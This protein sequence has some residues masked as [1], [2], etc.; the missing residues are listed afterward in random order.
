MTADTGSTLPGGVT[1]RTS[2]VPELAVGLT[3]L[4]LLMSTSF[5]LPFT[6]DEPN[7][8]ERSDQ[9]GIWLR[10]WYHRDL[11]QPFPWETD[12]IRRYCP[13]TTVSEGHPDFYGFVI[14]IGRL[15]SSDWLPP[16]ESYRFGPMLLFAVATACFFYRMRQDHGLIAAEIGVACLLSMPRLFAHA[17]FASI[18][19]PLT[20]CWI[21]MWATFDWAQRSKTGCF[22]WG[23]MLGLT[24]S[25]K[26]TG[27]LA[28]VPFVVWSV[29]YRHSW[30][31]CLL[32]GAIAVVTFVNVNPRLWDDPIGGMLQFLSLNLHRADRGLNV[33]SFFFGTRY[34]MHHPL[35]WY[36]PFVW[37]LVTV[38][39]GT[40]LM[41]AFGSI[42]SM[43]FW[44]REPQAILL[45][46]NAVILVIVKSM[47]FAPGHDAE[48]LFLPCFA[49]VAAL[50]GI[51]GVRIWTFVEGT[52]RRL[53]SS[54]PILALILISA[55][56]ETI[57]YAPQWLSYYSPLIGGLRGAAQYGM[58]PTYY[59][60]GLDH[61]TVAWLESH[62]GSNASVYLS[63]SPE[64]T[65]AMNRFYGSRLLFSSHHPG[66]CDWYLIQNRAGLW[67]DFDRKILEL[68]TPEFVKLIRDRNS[69][70][71]PWK[72]DVPLIFV[73]TREQWSHVSGES[74]LENDREG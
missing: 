13:Y 60:D 72:L 6:W 5:I 39:L 74:K 21:I 19:G 36:N 24:M 7:A 53:L 23:I 68:Q 63:V 52:K 67:S 59:W 16:K 2:L 12:A 8:I 70:I 26:F 15:A 62:S 11:G 49:F 41:A 32:G 35:P 50:S 25:C 40:V 34:D 46:L 44:R 37:L 28:I 14:A 20:A 18:D 17:H 1:G 22:A 64:Y 29:I 3:C 10:L 27:W 71:G 42:N 43:R 33:P 51:G 56:M 61:E 45:L 31:T 4:I 66:E 38:P 54:G 73:F 9:L 48:R 57:W 65:R 30:R 55:T 47:P 69:G 58:E